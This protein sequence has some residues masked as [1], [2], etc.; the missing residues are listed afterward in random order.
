MAQRHYGS[1]DCRPLRELRRFRTNI[2][3]NNKIQKNDQKA[4]EKHLQPQ[5]SE[6][7]D[8][9]IITFRLYIQNFCRE[10]II[11]QFDLMIFG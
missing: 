2:Q 8:K 5:R 10:D 6:M 11:A 1:R 7:C 4:A 9:T 3:A